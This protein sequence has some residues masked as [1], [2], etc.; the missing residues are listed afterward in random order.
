[1]AQR[2]IEVRIMVEVDGDE[3]SVQLLQ[4]LMDS[5]TLM[6]ASAAA[7]AAVLPIATLL[8][9]T[10]KVTPAWGQPEIGPECVVNLMRQANA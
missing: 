4:R 1:M 3:I 10:L 5:A 6:K 9:A 7:L 2:I 8:E